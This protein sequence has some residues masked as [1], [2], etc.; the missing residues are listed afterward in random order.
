MIGPGHRG[1]KVIPHIA[2]SSIDPEPAKTNSDTMRSGYSQPPRGPEYPL[3]HDQFG[4]S[5]VNHA[6]PSAAGEMAKRTI[7]ERT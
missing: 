4:A 6:F 3:R 2:S 7:K 5:T 1:C